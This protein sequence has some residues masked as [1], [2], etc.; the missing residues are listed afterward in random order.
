MLSAYIGNV[1]TLSSAPA[2]APMDDDGQPR[3]AVSPGQLQSLEWDWA[4]PCPNDMFVLMCD[5]PSLTSLKVSLITRAR[6]GGNCTR[7]DLINLSS[8]YTELESPRLRDLTSVNFSDGGYVYGMPHRMVIDSLKRF[9]TVYGPQLHHLRLQVLDP[10]AAV[11]LLNAALTCLQLRSLSLK[12]RNSAKAPNTEDEGAD[13]EMKSGRDAAMKDAMEQTQ[14]GGRESDRTP[15]P[16]SSADQRLPP[17][18]HLHEFSI[19]GLKL[20]D[21]R[22]QQLLGRLMPA[23]HCGLIIATAPVKLTEGTKRVAA[24]R[25]LQ[26]KVEEITGEVRVR[27]G[28]VGDHTYG[29]KERN[30]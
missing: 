24:S 9:L 26:V 23:F 30:E 19:R 5:I 20:G 2:A 6:A 4:L 10:I 25:G 12:F 1:A 21:R 3:P 7:D 29:G 22:L 15:I 14:V 17:L 18:K 28:R 8:L 16:L 13:A 27:V 11:P